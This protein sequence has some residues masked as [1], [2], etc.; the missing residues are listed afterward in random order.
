MSEIHSQLSTLSQPA[1]PEAGGAA[2]ARRTALLLPLAILAGFVLLFLLLFRD[3][4]IPATVVRVTPAIAVEE[5]SST[6][7][8]ASAKS[9]RMIFQASGWIEPDPLPIKATALTDGVVDQVNVL[10]GQTVKKGDLLATLIEADAKLE[11]TEATA[12]HE[13]AKAEFEAHCTNTQITLSQL[14]AERAGQAAD[15]ANADEAAERLRRFEQA[16]TS[17]VE[18]ERINARFENSRRQSALTARKAKIEE[19]THQLTKIAYEAAA[20]LA[21]VHTAEAALE[22]AK[23]MH[24]RT[25]ITAP[26]DGR[27]LRLTAA[28]GQKKML[29]M[30]E[31]DS[32]TIAVLYDPAHL[33]VRV[34]V[35]LADAAGL[36]V[37]QKAKVRCNLLPDQVFEGEVTRITGEADLQRNTLQAKVRIT[38]PDDR[39]R[40]EMLCR[41]E[42][43]DTA[44]ASG[45]S[46]EATSVA[47]Y[48]P[49]NALKE[50]AVWVC[51]PDTKRASRRQ[52]VSSGSRENLHRIDQ[53]I[54]PGE[55]VIL[56][57]SGLR[58][59]QRLHP[60]QKP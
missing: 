54:L 10:E 33:Q 32:S 25:R 38:A 18:L 43:L 59:N 8:P 9:G 51:D 1:A 34:D 4:L 42:F 23:L 41:V 24:S 15:Q 55:W 14:E 16:E 36:S 19:M 47:V 27:V 26:V 37:G 48:V 12:E 5:K 46:G 52:V 29:I 7:S 21:K 11:V 31:E 39:L 56:D 6:A 30:E 50:G 49:D 28:P 60:R 45:P 3:R 53:G 44:T 17:S 20:M 22:K 57:P 2:R 13:M 35:P 58:E 40:P